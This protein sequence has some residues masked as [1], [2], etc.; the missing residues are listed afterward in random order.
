MMIIIIT[1]VSRST[2]RLCLGSFPC[3]FV[4]ELCYTKSAVDLGPVVVVESND[5]GNLL[6][7]KPE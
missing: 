3:H 5:R 6:L 4:R 1:I 2:E 7:K